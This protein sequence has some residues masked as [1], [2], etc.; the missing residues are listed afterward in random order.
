MSGGERQVYT[1]RL[2]PEDAEKLEWMAGVS[3]YREG[4]IEEFAE[5]V[6]REALDRLVKEYEAEAA[7]ARKATED[8]E[9]GIPW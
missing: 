4:E 9:D 8:K 1:L 2:E 6:L 5:A 7:A 3:G